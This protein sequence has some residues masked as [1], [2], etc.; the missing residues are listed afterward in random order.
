MLVETLVEN[1]FRDVIAVIAV[2][3]CSVVGPWDMAEAI[4][5]EYENV[6]E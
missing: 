2:Q 1:S 5:V 4:L 6:V 3:A